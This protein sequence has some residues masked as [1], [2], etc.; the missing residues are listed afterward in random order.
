MS[1]HLP[2]AWYRA[3]N[4]VRASAIPQFANMRKIPGRT[5]ERPNT[6]YSWG[7]RRRATRTAPT[8]FISSERKLPTKR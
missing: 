3:R 5:R 6:P 8:A 2:S 1:P 4:L 7:V